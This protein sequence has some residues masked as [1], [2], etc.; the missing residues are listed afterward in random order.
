MFLAK[1]VIEKDPQLG[2]NIAS[3][4]LSLVTNVQSEDLFWFCEQVVQH[5]KNKQLKCFVL[6]I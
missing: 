5:S 2:I 6:K 1:Q 4:I 3:P